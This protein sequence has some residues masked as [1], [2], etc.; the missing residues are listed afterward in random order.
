MKLQFKVEE[1][2]ELQHAQ[3]LRQGRSSA[4]RRRKGEQNQL[5]PLLSPK[6]A[7]AQ[8]KSEKKNEDL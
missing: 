3:A 1:L 8:I 5:S 7:Y 2:R 6:Q 4:P